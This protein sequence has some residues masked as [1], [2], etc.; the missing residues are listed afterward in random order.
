MSKLPILA[1]PCNTEE[2]NLTQPYIVTELSG[3]DATYT[4]W[5]RETVTFEIIRRNEGNLQKFI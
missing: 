2:R 3:Q 5:R 1:A 4:G